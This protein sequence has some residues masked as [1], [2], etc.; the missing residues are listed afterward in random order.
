MNMGLAHNRR[1]PRNEVTIDAKIIFITVDNCRLQSSTP[2]SPETKNNT[3]WTMGVCFQSGSS[4][5]IML[6]YR[7][8]I[9]G[10]LNQLYFMKGQ[11]F[12][13]LVPVC[14]VFLKSVISYVENK[15][16]KIFHAIKKFG[17]I[18]V[19]SC[20]HFTPFGRAGSG[21]RAPSEYSLL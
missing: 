19:S 2:I 21:P 10:I 5:M 12:L 13:W 7:S 3:T 8:C 9:L 17:I 15:T 18:L 11:Q 14:Q 6:A 20:D 16:L 1:M 4:L